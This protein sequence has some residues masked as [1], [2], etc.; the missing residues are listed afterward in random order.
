M[1]DLSND[2]MKQVINILEQYVPHAEVW[3]FGSRVRGTAREHSDLDLVVI[4]KQKIPQKT[5]YQ[6]LEAFKESE[7]PIRVDVLDWHRITSEF[8]RNI[9]KQYEVVKKAVMSNKQ[10]V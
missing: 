5:Y 9:K 8:Q 10:R 4:D 3:A 1:I 6:L 7:L 2:L